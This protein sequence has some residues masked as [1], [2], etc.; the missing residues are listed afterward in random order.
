MATK[1]NRVYMNIRLIAGALL[2][3]SLAAHA[4]RA[5]KVVDNGLDD[6]LEALNAVFRFRSDLHDTVTVIAECRL[7]PVWRDSTQKVAID[8]RFRRQLVGPASKDS[9][10][11][12]SCGVAG[13]AVPNTQVLWIESIVEV[14]RT[15]A[16]AVD[17]KQ[18]E[19]TFQ[20]LLGPGYRQFQR[21]IVA[22][23]GIID[24]P[25][26]NSGNYQYAGWQVLE[27]KLLGADYDWGNG[28][29]AMSG[30][31]RGGL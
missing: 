20:F 12:K 13:F 28:L 3:S 2:L 7:P 21:H 1:Q 15:G 8:A 6:R 10:L 16:R 23:D 27:Y 31:R 19:I 9:A 14:T 30:F 17:Q 26:K 22:P 25:P 11:V 5:Q 4:A 29:G 18:F 24:A